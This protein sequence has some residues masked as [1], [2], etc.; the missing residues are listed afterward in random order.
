MCHVI[1]LLLL[2]QLSENRRVVDTSQTRQHRVQRTSTKTGELVLL[3]LLL[4]LKQL[5]LLS[6]ITPFR[7][8]MALGS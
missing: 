5:E 7:A 2:L 8:M 6:C 1:T 4:E 3:L